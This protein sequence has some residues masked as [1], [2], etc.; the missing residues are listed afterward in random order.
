MST[1]TALQRMMAE[2][3]RNGTSRVSKGT[4]RPR[5]A[6]SKRTKYSNLTCP[7][8]RSNCSNTEVSSKKM[9][10]ISSHLYSR[11][12]SIIL[13]IKQ[14]PLSLEVH[15]PEQSLP[16]SSATD[17][18]DSDNSHGGATRSSSTVNKKTFDDDSDA[19]S[20]YNADGE[21]SC[22]IDS[23][24]ELENANAFENRSILIHRMAEV[25]IFLDNLVLVF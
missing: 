25:L 19:E 20:S 14:H 13:R 4:T 18:S 24:A 10:R 11:P 1:T 21:V 17:S 7:I 5:Y 2:S 3:Q 8:T 15:L 9:A 23:F 16:S 12:S 22:V 6:A